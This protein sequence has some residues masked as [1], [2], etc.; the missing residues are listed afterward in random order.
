MVLS[1]DGILR[2]Y[3][4]FFDD[5]IKFLIFNLQFCCVREVNMYLITKLSE[6][7]LIKIIALNL[8]IATTF[9]LIVPVY[10]QEDNEKLLKDG[11]KLYQEAKL[12][13]AII[14]LSRY[15]ETPNLRAVMRAKAY[16][17]IAQAYM[18]KEFRDQANSAI[19]KLLNIMPHY[20]PDPLYDRPQFIQ[21]VKEV[22]KKRNVNPIPNDSQNRD[23]IK[24]WIL[25]GG[26][27]VVAVV[28]AIVFWPNPP[29]EEKL[30][31]PPNLPKI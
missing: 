24:K 4:V 12:D 8:I 3:L 5:I 21:L 29:E 15:I 11:I 19:E 18:A 1:I 28:L 10:A 14:K 7:I 27:A 17:Y 31:G 30:P 16:K 9:I 6:S 26:G 22:R 23:N 13:Q 20:K 2:K 25:I